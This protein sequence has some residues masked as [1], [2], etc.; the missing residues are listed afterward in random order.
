M[1]D[2]MNKSCKTSANFSIR[3]QIK[4]YGDKILLQLI[5]KDT[6]KVTFSFQNRSESS[7]ITKIGTQRGHTKIHLFFLEPNDL[8]TNISMKMSTNVVYL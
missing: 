1:N 5:A 3:K 2:F 6:V 4:Y 8:K 7:R